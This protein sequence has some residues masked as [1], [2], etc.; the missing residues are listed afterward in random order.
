MAKF[1]Q[2]SRSFHFKSPEE[3]TPDFY[4]P[5]HFVGGVPDWVSDHPFFKMAVQGGDITFVG[6]NTPQNSGDDSGT[7]KRRS[8]RS[9]DS[10]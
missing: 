3:G 7:G 1:I 5:A 10:E 6:E 4:I 2:S 9:T 8:K